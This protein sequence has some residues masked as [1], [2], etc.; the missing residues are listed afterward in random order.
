MLYYLRIRTIETVWMFTFITVYQ[1]H[2]S[3]CK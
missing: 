2:D 3:N 1:P